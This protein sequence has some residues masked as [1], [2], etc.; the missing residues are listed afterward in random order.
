MDLELINL[1]QH[2]PTYLLRAKLPGLRFAFDK[3]DSP[4]VEY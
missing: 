2:R 4:F 1:C 3:E